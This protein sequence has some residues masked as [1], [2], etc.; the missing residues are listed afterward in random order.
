MG[1]TDA[2]VF[3][4]DVESGD[5]YGFG[6]IAVQLHAA[7]GLLRRRVRHRSAGRCPAGTGVA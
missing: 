7:P 6:T 2:V 5:G 4:V 1:N 3:D